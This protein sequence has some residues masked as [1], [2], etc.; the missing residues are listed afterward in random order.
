[1]GLQCQI[2]V[3]GRGIWAR[4]LSSRPRAGFSWAFTPHP[5]RRSRHRREM[6]ADHTE[7]LT[8]PDDLS[9]GSLPFPT[10]TQPETPHLTPEGGKTPHLAQKDAL[11]YVGLVLSWREKG[12]RDRDRPTWVGRVTVGGVKKEVGSSVNMHLTAL[13]VNKALGAAVN[14]VACFGVGEVPKEDWK[15]R[16]CWAPC[17]CCCVC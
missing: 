3:G 5:E 11:G 15:C 14:D 7:V 1:M 17:L 6:P 12:S 8:P 4:Y 10:G 2:W 16:T 13:K 9:S